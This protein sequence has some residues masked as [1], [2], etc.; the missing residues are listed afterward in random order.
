MKLGSKS[1]YGLLALAELV[2]SYRE[3]RPMQVREIAQR[4]QIPE[5]Y[6]GQ[7]MVSLKRSRLVHASRGPGGGYFLSRPPETIT[8]GE[9]VRLLDGPFTGVEL[10]QRNQ[11]PSSI[12]ARK[13]RDTWARG[14]EALEKAL[15]E[16]TLADLSRAEEM[17]HM[18]Y[19]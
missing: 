13:I 12:V 8:V 7:I 3:H 2:Q 9:V 16:I 1:F 11:L 14:V 4:N 18:Y 10:T 19:I 15:E 5:E 17:P 6:L